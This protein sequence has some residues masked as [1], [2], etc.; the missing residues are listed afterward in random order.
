MITKEK[1]EEFRAASLEL[2]QNAK[3]NNEMISAL[4]NC[5]DFLT[6]YAPNIT[7]ATDHYRKMNFLLEELKSSNK[8]DSAQWMSIKLDILPTLRELTYRENE[9]I[10]IKG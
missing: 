1:F 2:C 6:A 9:G 4:N 5:I 7:I 8:V 10:N 3:S